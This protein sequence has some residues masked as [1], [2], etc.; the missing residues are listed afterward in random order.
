MTIGKMGDVAYRLSTKDPQAVHCPQLQIFLQVK[1]C[2]ELGLQLCA[3]MPVC[4]EQAF[5]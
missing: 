1:N 2:R 3:T 4:A 5:Y